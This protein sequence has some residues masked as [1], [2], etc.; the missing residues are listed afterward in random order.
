MIFG[1]TMQNCHLNIVKCTGD[2]FFIYNMKNVYY[3]VGDGR[4]LLHFMV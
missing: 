3:F 2:V 1:K 4:F